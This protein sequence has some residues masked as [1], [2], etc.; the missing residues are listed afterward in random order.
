MKFSVYSV[1]KAYYLAATAS[2][3][4][5][6]WAITYWGETNLPPLIPAVRYFI[7]ALFANWF[8][9]YALIIADPKVSSESPRGWMGVAVIGVFLSF[10]WPVFSGDLMEYLIRGRMLAIYHVSPYKAI[11]VDFPNDLLRPF[12]IWITNPDSYGPLSVYIQTIPVMLFPNSITGMIWGY[13]VI[14]LAFLYMALYFFWN[15]VREL[16]WVEGPRLWATFAYCPLLL[17]TA[18]IDGHNDIIMMAFSVGSVYFLIRQK[19]GWSFFFWTCGFLV[20]YMIFF[21]LPFMV[22]I[23]VRTIGAKER[24]FPWKF[25]LK[26]VFINCLWIVVCFAP[27]WGGMDTFLAI[28]RQKG[29]FYTNTVPYLFYLALT[30]LKLPANQEIIKF[31]FLGS[32][33]VFY[34]YLLARSGRRRPDD[35]LF[36]FRA[37]ALAYLAF[38]AAL[39]SPMGFWYLSW[40]VFLIVLAKWPQGFA[41][42]LI[43]SAVGV[44][45]FFKRINFLLALG[46]LGYVAV[47]I[48]SRFGSQ[49]S[50]K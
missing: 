47:L 20:K 44:V 18:F 33:G 31:L 10:M 34:V 13:K 12:S 21:Q 38:Y 19:Y 37:S 25:V 14:I 8:L 27:V 26:M 3:G 5:I 49:K 30:W 24:S 35:Y 9:A 7:L 45:A 48:Q 29:A 17:M 28:L 22:L 4:L 41:L 23:A 40:A 50:P 6:A 1:K 46:A 2:L 43:Y 11:P 42:V 39:P 15:I 16:R 32:F 36:F